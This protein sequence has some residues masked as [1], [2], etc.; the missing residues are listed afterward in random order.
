MRSL[1]LHCRDDEYLMEQG[2]L[3]AA[4]IAGFIDQAL[5][6]DARALAAEHLASCQQCRDELA[7]CA[8]LAA[9]APA[10]RP[11]RLPWRAVAGTAAVLVLAIVLRSRSRQPVREPGQAATVERARPAASTV[12]TVFPSENLE[13]ARARP[14]FVWRR[15]EQAAAYRLVVTDANGRPVWNDDVRD[16]VFTLPDTARLTPSAHYF[17]RVD[18]LH[19]DGTTSES[20]EVAFRVAP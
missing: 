19:A 3:S 6:A 17:W 14:R 7:V 8:R 12:M 11:R 2:H 5:D 1:A 4:E 13:I 18:A 16:T 20:A 10:V 9:S 15:D